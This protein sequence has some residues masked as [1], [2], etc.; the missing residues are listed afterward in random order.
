MNIDQQLQSL[1]ATLNPQATLPNAPNV[2]ITVPVNVPANMTV[3][4]VSPI[5]KYFKWVLLAV[6]LGLLF[7]F[8]T[9]RKKLLALKA[10]SNEPVRVPVNNPLPNPPV[11]TNP[12]AN[13]QNQQPRSV[14]QTVTDPN[15]TLL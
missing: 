10:R 6:G 1:R 11:V 14:A 15:F 12:V 7:V 9:K 3:T 13:Q 2:P 4:T 5:K 8:F